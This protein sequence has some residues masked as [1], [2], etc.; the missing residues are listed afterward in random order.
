MT[1]T[2]ANKPPRK[3]NSYNPA[4]TKKLL[5]LTSM[6]A[7]GAIWLIMLRYL[8]MA[9][10]I[11]AFQD[12]KV[13]PK[14]P[15]LLNNIIHSKFVGLDNFK[16]LFSS[17][18]SWI[19]IRNTVGYNLVFI[20]LGLVISVA[21]AILLFELPR[22]RIAKTY[23]T[24]MFFPYFLSWVVVSYFLFA[25]LSPDKGLINMTQKAAWT[26]EGV[27]RGT[28]WYS[29]TGPWPYILTFANVWKNTGYTAIL[30]L[31]TITGIDFSQYEAAR[32]DGANRWQQM[33]YVTLPN[34]KPMITILLI[35]N[36]G[37]IFNADFGLFYSLR[38]GSGALNSV[39]QVI[40]TYVYA[41]LINTRGNL[42][43]TTAAGLFQNVVGFIFLMSA[44]AVVRKIDPDNALF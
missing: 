20:A 5:A 12:Y 44:N 34:I 36:L 2:A 3:K 15:S 41:A 21:F 35:M 10:I 18:D 39:T 25:F 4:K 22:K 30:Y 32:I 27:F 28:Q 26:G 16:F 23:Q 8:P 29:T 24:V 33:K 43:M 31:A 14:G 7:P 1:L 17:T 13:Y 40:D 42:G 11:I 6:A 37:K 38:M 9:G 19:M